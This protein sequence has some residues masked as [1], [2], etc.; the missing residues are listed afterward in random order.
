MRQPF[1]AEWHIEELLK[2]SEKQQKAVMLDFGLTAEGKAKRK[3]TKGHGVLTG[4]LRR[5]IHLANV[6]YDWSSDNVPTRSVVTTKKGAKIRL[7]QGP[8]RGGKPV[9]PE[10]IGDQTVLALGS[11][12]DYAMA[13]H[14]GW[15]PFDGYHYLTEGTSDAKNDMPAIIARHPMEES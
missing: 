5:S 4:T 11:G 15:G 8:E 7:L 3:L 10:K 12:M 2:M 6:D 9:E 13:I 14:Q 1:E